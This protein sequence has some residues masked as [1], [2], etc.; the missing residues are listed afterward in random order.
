MPRSHQPSSPSDDLA[1][2]L[3][4]QGSRANGIISDEIAGFCQS[5]ISVIVAARG[6]DGD[7]IAGLALGCTID[8]AGSVRILL[9]RSANEALLEALLAGSRIAATFSRPADHRSIQLKGSNATLLGTRAGDEEI[10]AAQCIGMASELVNAGYSQAF[11]AGYCEFAFPD[12]VVVAFEPEQI[13][14][15][16]P[17]P[18][19]G[20]RLQ[21]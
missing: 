14:V 2:F 20:S 1:A 9:R 3:S 5:G 10:L 18:G 8:T 16:T 15:Q 12:I 21:P 4:R 19:A 11:A 6:R 17:G 7:P 13:F